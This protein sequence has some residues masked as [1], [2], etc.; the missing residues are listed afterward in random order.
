MMG[1]AGVAE[2]D[3]GGRGV[4]L[5]H[6]APALRRLWSPEP[7]LGIRSA[8]GWMVP[9]PWSRRMK[10]QCITCPAGCCPPGIHA[11]VGSLPQQAHFDPPTSCPP[12]ERGARGI[13]LRRCYG[14]PPLAR[15]LLPKNRESM[16]L[17]FTVGSRGSSASRTWSLPAVKIKQTEGERPLQVWGV[18][19]GGWQAEV[20][21]PGFTCGGS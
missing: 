8:S 19:N 13:P 12:L 2:G 21:L 7:L 18:Q 17:T 9:S 3:V 11:S 10:G 5:D 1:W 15:G 20:G 14:R 4:S 16:A 6:A